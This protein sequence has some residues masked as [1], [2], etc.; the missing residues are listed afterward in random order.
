MKNCGFHFGQLPPHYVNIFLGARCKSLSQCP[1][2]T[3]LGLPPRVPSWG[4]G[5][6][7]AGP[8]CRKKHLKVPMYIS[9]SEMW[10]NKLW[11]Q[12]YHVSEC[13]MSLLGKA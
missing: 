3:A 4:L 1:G 2:F 6:G 10:K 11:Q 8:P 13:V 5:R 9:F 12:L 7:K